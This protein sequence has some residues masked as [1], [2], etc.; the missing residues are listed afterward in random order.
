MLSF[1]ALI[2]SANAASAEYPDYLDAKKVYV[3]CGM[4]AGTGWYINRKSIDVTQFDPPNFWLAVEVAVVPRA[5]EGDLTDVEYVCNEY[6][7]DWTNRKMYAVNAG[8]K[9]FIPPYGTI[10][11]LPS[12][13][14][15]EL[16]FFIKYRKKFYGELYA[17][18]N[19]NF[20]K[21]LYGYVENAEQEEIRRRH[22]GLN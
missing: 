12:S 19:Y 4:H 8:E 18:K 11:E 15:G 1:I 5:G 22:E 3:L 13:Y 14:D 2:F 16:A 20:N 17:D 21:N 7:Y 10:A 9:I 6:F